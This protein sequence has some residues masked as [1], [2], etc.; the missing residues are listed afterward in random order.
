MDS[1]STTS[2][3][4][5]IVPQ[6]DQEYRAKASK[7]YQ[8][9]QKVLPQHAPS[10]QREI[11]LDSS[12]KVIDTVTHPWFLLAVSTSTNPSFSLGGGSM[13]NARGEVV[14]A[15]LALGLLLA[16]IATFC[17]GINQAYLADKKAK[18]LKET[19]ELL[20]NEQN[21]KVKAV[22]EAMIPLLRDE[23]I[24]EAL[25]TTGTFAIAGGLAALTAAAVYALIAF[26]FN[27][28]TPSITY[29]LA[30]IGSGVVVG[31]GLGELL[32]FGLAK[33]KKAKGSQL[34]K[35]QL[36]LDNLAYDLPLQN[37]GTR[38]NCYFIHEKILYKRAGT[39]ITI[40]PYN[41]EKPEG[42]THI[43]STL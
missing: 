17:G 39:T 16:S 11:Q 41:G 25:Q 35:L 43:Q 15:M 8:L 2:V 34:Q 21:E 7:A 23:V 29:K 40:E 28:H 6:G 22:Y 27:Y 12:I 19:K 18:L 10:G 38:D 20:A 32:V 5:F 26:H 1:S 24:Q 36:A 4:S 30:I 9:A 13:G 37:F 3:N 14:L 42:L 31:G 33:L